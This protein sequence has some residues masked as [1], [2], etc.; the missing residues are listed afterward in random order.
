[1]NFETLEESVNAL[2]A[3]DACSFIAAET[4]EGIGKKRRFGI[5]VCQQHL[6]APYRNKLEVSGN[7]ELE[8]TSLLS[9]TKNREK[10]AVRRI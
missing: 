10:S 3:V 2:P 7:V 4:S 1:M 6:L 9:V 5:H 8:A